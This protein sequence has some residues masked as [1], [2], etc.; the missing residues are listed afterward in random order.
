LKPSSGKTD[1]PFSTIHAIE[2]GLL[3]REGSLEDPTFYENAPQWS[4]DEF[5]FGMAYFHRLH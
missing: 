3:D 2:T 5:S 4:E 1:A